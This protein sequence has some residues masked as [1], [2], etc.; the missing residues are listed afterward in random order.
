MPQAHPEDASQA[1]HAPQMWPSL[2]RSVNLRQGQNGQTNDPY[3]V[4]SL[5]PQLLDSWGQR[6]QILPSLSKSSWRMPLFTSQHLCPVSKPVHKR[7]FPYL[8]GGTGNGSND[9]KRPNLYGLHLGEGSA[10]GFIHT[11]IHWM[12]YNWILPFLSKPHPE[13]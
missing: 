13:M 4:P 8:Q 12:F 2:L 3:C 10:L 6:C 9:C 11:H 5:L 7:P 1:L